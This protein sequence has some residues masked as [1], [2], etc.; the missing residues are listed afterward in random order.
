MELHIEMAIGSCVQNFFGADLKALAA[1]TPKRRPRD[2]PR[3]PITAGIKDEIRPKNRL[4]RQC[5][6]TRDPNLKNDVSSHP[7]SHLLTPGGIA[8]SDSE[9]AEAL[10]ENLETRLSR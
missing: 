6:I 1:S 7:I 9:K 8:F 4:Q 5:Q 10:E 2:N 3:P